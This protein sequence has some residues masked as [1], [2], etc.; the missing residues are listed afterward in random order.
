MRSGVGYVPE[1]R[2]VFTGLTVEENLRLAE[3]RG[4][5]RYDGVFALFPELERRARQRAGTLSGGQQQMLSIARVLLNDQQLLF[6][7]EP[8]KGLAPALVSGVVEVLER[9]AE[10]STVLLVEQNLHAVRR[11]AQRFVVL[12]HGNVVYAG[13]RRGPRR[14]RAR[15]PPARGL[16]HAV[17][18]FLAISFSGLALGAVYFLIASGLSLIYGLM[19]VLNFA[20]GAFMTVGAYGGWALAT[21]LPGS[22]PSALRFCIARRRAR[23]PAE[24]CSPRSPSCSSSAACTA[25]RRA[26]SSSPSA[27]TSPSWRCSTAPSRATRVRSRCRCGCSG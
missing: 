3:T 14:R 15:A 18:A 11:L 1:D 20:H 25:I 22:L 2:D 12:D 7:D 26:R 27:S 23:S 24:R 9:A 6:V 13:G 10:R 5:A 19:E 4:P 16:G 8:T 17:S 21:Y